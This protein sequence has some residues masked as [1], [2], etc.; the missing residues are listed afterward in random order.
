MPRSCSRPSATSCRWSIAPMAR[1]TWPSARKCRA[2]PRIGR[3]CVRAGQ[4]RQR[5]A[6]SKLA[7]GETYVALQALASELRA[8]NDLQQRRLEA[9]AAR[10]GAAADRTRVL[11]IALGVHRAVAR[12]R[13]VVAGD[14]F[15]DAADAPRH[16]RRQP[17]QGRWDLTTTIHSSGRDETAQQ[18]AAMGA[19]SANLRQSSATCA[20]ASIRCHRP[21]RRSPRATRTCAA[22]RRAG[23]H[24]GGDRRVD[25]TAQ[26]ARSSRTPT[27]PQQANQLAASR[28]ARRPA[29][30]RRGGRAGGRPR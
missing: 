12:R 8:F 15:G 24:A 2:L 22:H 19:M 6:A 1:P 23:Q 14:P 18:L 27:T 26:P 30:G 10:S 5:D 17:H 28:L 11:V 9:A 7:Y 16:S 4:R 3:A 25:G 29:A 20:T 21:A 13:V